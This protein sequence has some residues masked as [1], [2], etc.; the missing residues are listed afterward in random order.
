[1][2]SFL[3]TLRRGAQAVIQGINQ[4]EMMQAGL[5][6]VAEKVG[7][8]LEVST[9]ANPANLTQKVCTKIRETRDLYSKNEWLEPNGP[10][11]QL[12]V[13]FGVSP[14]QIKEVLEGSVE[15]PS[16]KPVVS[17]PTSVGNTSSASERRSDPVPRQRTVGSVPALVQVNKTVDLQTITVDPNTW[18]NRALSA[19]HNPPTTEVYGVDD[20]DRHI[21]RLVLREGVLDKVKR[22]FAKIRHLTRTQVNVLVLEIT[23]E[24]GGVS[25]PSG[26]SENDTA[27][28]GH[29]DA[30]SDSGAN[31]SAPVQVVASLP[32][33]TPPSQPSEAASDGITAD[34]K[35]WPRIFSKDARIVDNV[36]RSIVRAVVAAGRY[37]DLKAKIQEVRRLGGQQVA[38]IKATLARRAA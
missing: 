23:R 9:A 8:S 26:S 18:P 34:P 24:L 20:V 22:R 32:Q 25:T 17:P 21:M 27:L 16:Q 6:R 29:G 36:D 2:V 3:Q 11:D 12:C 15:P 28:P 30:L 38:G 10:R 4:L 31:L 33:I 35:T 5:Q 14:Q 37:D 13:R 1:M 7:V 19:G